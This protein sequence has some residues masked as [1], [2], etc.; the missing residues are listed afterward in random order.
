MPGTCFEVTPRQ[1]IRSDRST[2]SL[3]A[4]GR[5]Q[6]KR[7]CLRASSVGMH[8]Q[9]PS[10][11]SKFLPTLP[12]KLGYLAWRLQQLPVGPDIAAVGQSRN[13]FSSAVSQPSGTS[14]SLLRQMK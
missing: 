11:Y 9:E 2:S 13:G 8:K 4:N 14:T 6:A 5:Y 10:T 3:Y 12:W 1:R 7:V